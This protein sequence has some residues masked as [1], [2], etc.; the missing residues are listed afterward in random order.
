MRKLPTGETTEDLNE[1]LSAW[2]DLAKPICAATGLDVLCYDPAITFT[3]HKHLC[4]ELPV[5]FIELINA[6]ILIAERA[7]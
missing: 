1:Y 6:R 5:Q 2:S 3:D 4:V 7:V